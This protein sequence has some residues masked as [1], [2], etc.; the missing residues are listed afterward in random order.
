M[1]KRAIWV[2]P[3]WDQKNHKKNW[4]VFKVKFGERIIVDKAD[5]VEKIFC[6]CEMHKNNKNKCYAANRT[7]AETT[8]DKEKFRIPVRLCQL[9]DRKIIWEEIRED[10]A[11]EKIRSGTW[12]KPDEPLMVD[13]DEDYFGCE[14]GAKY[15]VSASVKWKD[16]ELL[17]FSISQLIC[18][19]LT[20][21]E[22]YADRLFIKITKEAITKCDPSN[23]RCTDV[24][25]HIL[26]F[27]KKIFKLNREKKFLCTKN[28]GE[29]EERITQFVD[30][31]L[32]LNQKQLKALMKT[33]FCMQTTPKSYHFSGVFQVCHGFNVPGNSVVLYHSPTTSEVKQRLE[34]LKSMLTNGGL[35]K[36]NMV[37]VCRSVRDGYTPREYFKYIESGINECLQRQYGVDLVSIRYDKD[38]LGGREGWPRNHINI[39]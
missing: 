9:S 3:K 32:T 5:N 36:P 17:D 39:G 31:L 20:V 14:S 8:H 26:L 29:L 27:T 19:K 24:Y 33:G 23:K 38:L 4:E 12:I 18:P 1:F 15:L 37:T 30:H 34:L 22:A 7:L 25:D 16:I 11:M 6:I 10:M 21:Q 2:W 13:I 28:V 35:P